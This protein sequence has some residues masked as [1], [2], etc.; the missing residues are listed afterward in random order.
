MM[1]IN[2]EVMMSANIAVIS[3]ASLMAVYLI[4]GIGQLGSPAS[5]PK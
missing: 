3:Y 2:L 5:I 4:A 1:K